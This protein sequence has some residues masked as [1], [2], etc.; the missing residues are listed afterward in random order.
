M[1]FTYLLPITNITAGIEPRVELLDSTGASLAFSDSTSAKL[2]TAISGSN[3][4][5]YTTQW[6]RESLPF[7]VKVSNHSTGSL[8]ATAAFNA[9][10]VPVSISGSG[11]IETTIYVE[12]GSSNPIQGVA[13]WVT[14]DSSGTN[15]VAGTLVTDNFGNVTFYLDA[16]TYY[17]WKQ[18]P[19]YTFSNPATIVVT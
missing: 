7:T 4:Y 19:L 13:V 14:T 3:Y 1:A 2:A 6:P 10:D 9:Y 8:L 11:G 5:L 12:D 16:G 15:I 17:V 18:K